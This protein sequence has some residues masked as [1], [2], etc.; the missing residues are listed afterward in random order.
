MDKQFT[1]KRMWQKTAE[2]IDSLYIKLAIE[3]KEIPKA[4]IIDRAVT[5]YSNRRIAN[6]KKK[7]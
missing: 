6:L 1:L 5:Q 4:D 7:K 2:K 3:N